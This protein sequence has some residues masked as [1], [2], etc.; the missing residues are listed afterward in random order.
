[1]SKLVP[2]DA[3]DD[4]LEYV[5]DSRHPLNHGRHLAPVL[6][7]RVWYGIDDDHA[8]VSA[9]QSLL[10]DDLEKWQ[11]TLGLP[12]ADLPPGEALRML[13]D[14]R[15][16]Q[17][18]ALEVVLF[19]WAAYVEQLTTPYLAA[20]LHCSKRTVQLK[21]AAGRAQV[22]QLIAQQD[23]VD[24][25]SNGHSRDMSRADKSGQPFLSLP[26]DDAP[27]LTVLGSVRST[28]CSQQ[29]PCL[30]LISTGCLRPNQSLC[31]AD[32]TSMKRTEDTAFVWACLL[33][34]LLIGYRLG[35]NLH[36]GP[37]IRS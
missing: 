31:R 7:G 23:P 6:I 9:V 26:P 14:K 5:R 27:A 33:I 22:A 37:L 12:L 18:R 15:V 20:E 34:G 17:H 35:K 16:A 24:P 1:M 30:A 4:I 11:R 2:Q 13:R 19:V 28:P 21:L 10:S 32:A 8:L 25:A 3:V 29:Q 36:R